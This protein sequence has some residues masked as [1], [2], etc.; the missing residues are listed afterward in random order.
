MSP[1]AI[2]RNTIL[3]L[4][5]IGSLL[6]PSLPAT[7]SEASTSEPFSTMSESTHIAPTYQISVGVVRTS[8]AAG[9]K[10]YISGN[11]LNSIYD[12]RIS[13]TKDFLQS[14]GFEVGDVND[15]MLAS[16]P[17]LK[18]FDVLVFPRTLA[19]TSDQRAAIRAYVSEGGGVVGSYG[20]SRWDADL[21]Y[22]HGYL[23][24]LGMHGHPGVYTWPPNSDSLKPWEWGEIS[25]VFN[26]KFRNDPLMK[27]PY[28]LE[29]ASSH[30]I[31]QDGFA[32]SAS[33]TMVAKRDDYNEVVYSMA[34]A[35][36]VTPL[37]TFNTLSNGHV[38]DNAETGHLAGWTADYYFGRLV[39][40]GFQLHDL[41]VGGVYADT[42][43]MNVARKVLSNSVRWAGSPSTYTHVRKDAEL[44]GH[45]WY[46]RGTLYIDETV[47]NTG[48]TS[49]RGPLSVEVRNPSGAVVY[50]GKAY[51]NLTPLPPGGSYTHK[52]YAV[53]LKSPQK[54]IWTIKMSYQYYD[55]FSGGWL[56]VNR[57]IF[58]DSTGS[59][60]SGSRMGPQ[61]IVGAGNRP[62]IG[63]R[64]AGTSRYETNV[65]LSQRG[66]PEGVSES[67]AVILATGTGY[68]DALAAAPLAGS[69]DAP[70]LLVPKDGIPAVLATELRRLYAGRQSGML[71]VVGGEAAISASVAGEARRI[72]TEAGV[73]TVEIDR[74]QGPNRYG[75]A[76]AIAERVG[77][78]SEGTFADT[79]IIVSGQNY[80]D[81][82]AISGLAAAE[83]V[84]ILPV[85]AESVPEE[86]A[87][88]LGSLGVKHS[89]IVGG[90]AAVSSSVESWL[91]SRG[92][93]RPGVQ[94][95]TMNVDTRLAG[96]SRYATALLAGEFAVEL[97]GFTTR[98][99]YFAT[100]RNW[101]DALGL[102]SVAGKE[103]RAV[104]LVHGTEIASSVVVANNLMSRRGNPPTCTFIGGAGAIT[105]YVR[106]QVRVALGL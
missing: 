8:T 6:L 40:F 69:L 98:D 45:G 71:V 85:R 25:E 9:T 52:S 62:V 3:A 55:Y 60:M 88:A 21:K 31:L 38:D 19:T 82:L 105:D 78:P 4:L 34:G 72:L 75:T 30:W 39:Y 17:A 91:E 16:A 41:I 35:R 79:A 102:G 100:G 33:R 70:V 13:R 93:R 61:T 29:P 86:I 65:K 14:E 5:L 76:K 63:T 95:G 94:A 32:E 64:I 106:G 11:P 28:S 44:S 103:Q 43:S 56:G 57:T 50:T 2:G 89:T 1:G 12:D 67:G 24:F 26:V 68:S 27:G 99:V 104:V 46:T 83:G 97:G 101:P 73:T 96:S 36:N 42:P 80:P 49:L 59:A 18:Q 22:Q 7:G 92:H 37:F 10:D 58:L 54:G 87:G 47:K 74:L 77:V 20:L 90:T 15:A 51:D 81:A 23:P 53:P 66:W 48:T 84:P